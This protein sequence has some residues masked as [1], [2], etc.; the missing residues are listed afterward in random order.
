MFRDVKSKNLQKGQLWQ[1]LNLGVRVRW[2]ICVRWSELKVAMF[3]EM[4]L[5]IVAVSLHLCGWWWLVI[6]GR[7][8]QTVPSHSDAIAEGYVPLDFGHARLQQLG[9]KQELKRGLSYVSLL[10]IFSLHSFFFFLNLALNYDRVISNFA[11]SFCIISGLTGVTTLYNTRL[12]YGGTV[13]IVYGWFIVSALIFFL[14][15]KSSAEP[16][17]LPRIP[18]QCHLNKR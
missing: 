7:G 11:F 9:Y 18:A 6:M 3:K 4:K 14:P 5:Y 10:S 16:F 12:N 15:Q 8:N 1:K 13:S 17:F 2:L